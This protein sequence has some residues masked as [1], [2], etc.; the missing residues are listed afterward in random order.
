MFIL[1][2]KYKIELTS[3]LT[4]PKPKHLHWLVKDQK[5]VTSSCHCFLQANQLH[6]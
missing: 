6:V 3:N 5:A 4:L 1:T 2:F